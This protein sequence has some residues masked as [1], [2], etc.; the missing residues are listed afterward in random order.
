[1]PTPVAKGI[2]ITVSALVAAG[3]AVYESPQFRQWVN[4]SRR[5]IA[6]A[7]HN[8]GDEINPH[9]APLR[10]D[11][12]MTEEVGVAAEERRRIA[13]EEL[14]RRRSLLEE[15]RKG[16]ARPPSNSFD[17]LV[18]E[19]GRLLDLADSSSDTPLAN[20]TA[21]EVAT[22]Q[23][24]HRGKGPT[25]LPE[26]SHGQ[27][28]FHELGPPLQLNIPSPRAGSPLLAEFTPVSEAPD[29]MA[30]S[31]LS[32]S[33][34]EDEHHIVGDDE[35]ISS[36]T[37]GHS[38]VL[39]AHPGDWTTNESGRDLRSPF[40]DLAELQLERER[41][42][43][44]STSDSYSHIYESAIDASSDGT[45]SDLGRSTG[46]ATPASWSE[47]GSVISNDEHVHHL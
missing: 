36:H 18:D 11:I 39:Y 29:K 40:S 33:H 34:A 6:L 43:T 21:V 46:A 37:E 16:M 26:A 8:L 1:M 22:S 15:R 41:A 23:P 12:S 27:T 14:D 30:T 9:D 4:N 35:S 47:V 28:D 17:T 3:I 7:L 38:E 25:S 24:V 20:S 42:S 2:I 45:L 44:P 5:K 31:L 10:Q 19:Q 32:S 13:R